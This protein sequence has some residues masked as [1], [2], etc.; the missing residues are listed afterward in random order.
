MDNEAMRPMVAFGVA[1]TV[2]TEIAS[3][4]H[5]VTAPVL[6]GFWT[7]IVCVLLVSAFVTLQ[8]RPIR[9]S[10][11]RW[12]LLEGAASAVIAGILVVVGY[13]A[14]LSPPNSADAMAYHLPRVLY[15]VQ[16][17]SVAFFPTSYLNQIMLQPGME[18]IQLHLYL[19]SGG[20]RFA[21]LVQFSAFA[22][23]I[24]GVW[25][26]AG[27]LALP[28]TGQWIAAVSCATLPNGILQAS[29]A[30]NDVVLSLWIVCAVFFALRADTVFL[31]L[32]I[33]LALG[34]KGTAYLFVP[35][36]VAGALVANGRRNYAVLVAACAAGVLVLNAPQYAR[37]YDLSG[38]LLGFDSAQADGQFRWR[39]EHLGWKATASNALRNLSE[40][41]GSRHEQWNTGVYQVV[42]RMHDL[43][44]LEP[45][46]PQTTWP[47]A[48]FEPPRNANHEA[49]ANNRWHLLLSICGIAL[50][51][52]QA[53]AKKQTQCLW[54]A[55]GITGAFLAFCF[56]LKWQPFFSR[57]LLPLFILATPLMAFVVCK[58]KPAVL[59]FVICLLLVSNTRLA[60]FQ[61][62]TRPLQGPGN[63]LTQ[64]REQSYFNDM[65]QWNNRESYIAA[66][67][68]V[69]STRCRS[70][71]IDNSVNHVE[72]PF[73]ALVLARQPT[74]QF[75]H[76]GVKN[77]SSKYAEGRAACAVLCLDCA[78]MPDK[79]DAY[80]V[81]GTPTSFGRFVVFS[82]A[83]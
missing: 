54:Y 35:P 13:V 59:G 78:G 63:L 27:L 40:Q 73:Q 72:Y 6:I 28:R 64:T 52:W 45:Q 80:K 74:T 69:S 3:A 68:A 26:I 53:I 12:T 57:L 19:L 14:W 21:N 77:A 25:R 75:L 4:M 7:A 79:M 15:W 41:L 66:A 62:W 38:S 2:V 32:S 18:Y 47:G 70:V 1:V 42:L 58:L 34:T 33:G 76:V 60:L 17:K 11:P 83:Y 10:L 55:L 31:A 51:A 36:I 82:P 65:A 16:N 48:R 56:Y 67:E 9:P 20:D 37:N 29:G 5:A 43:L 24:A 22:G 23:C 50:A 61:N 44:H 8:R 71:G 49:N 81:V 39:N 30:K 46:N